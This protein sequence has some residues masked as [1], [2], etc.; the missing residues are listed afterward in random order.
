MFPSLEIGGEISITQL[1]PDTQTAF[2]RKVTA[3]R[4]NKILNQDWN[5]M[6]NV[7]AWRSVCT[8]MR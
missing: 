2:Q 5:D 4:P 6:C 7:T 1:G 3:H 8:C